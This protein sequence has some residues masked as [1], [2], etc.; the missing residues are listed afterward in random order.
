MACIDSVLVNK[1]LLSKPDFMIATL[2]V[3]HNHKPPQKN[4]QNHLRGWSSKVYT[5]EE[6]SKF[7][8][9]QNGSKKNNAKGDYFLV[10]FWHLDFEP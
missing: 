1:L 10:S 6:G 9:P 7:L 4:H 2:A 8:D 3:M 5:I